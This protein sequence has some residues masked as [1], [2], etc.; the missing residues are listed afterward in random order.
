MAKSEILKR[1]VNLSLCPVDRHRVARLDGELLPLN[2]IE[3]LESLGT[4][5]GAS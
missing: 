5:D 2:E 3:L 1:D 4:I